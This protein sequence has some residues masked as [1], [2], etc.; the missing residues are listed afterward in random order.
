[1]KSVLI[2]V[3]G[4][5]PGFK[6]GGPVRTISNMIEALGDEISFSVICLDRD[7]GDKH[8]YPKISKKKWNPQGKANVFYIER[9]PIGVFNILHL[10]YQNKYNFI[11]LNSSLSFQFSILPL[12]LLKI[13][14]LK[15]PAI[16]GP[17]GEFS[18]G[19]LSIKPY[20]KKFFIKLAKLLHLYQ[21]VIWHASSA[22]EATD[23]RRVMGQAVDIRIATDI[24]VYTDDI[25][26]P[27]RDTS[28]PLKIAFIARIS[29]MKNLDYA[30]DI[31][32]GVSKSVVFDVYG[33]LEETSYWEKCLQQTNNLP[34]NIKFNYLGTLQPD[35]VVSTLTNYDLFFLP[36]KG[37]NFGHVIAEALFAGLPVLISDQTPWRQLNQKHLGWDLSLSNQDSFQTAIDQCITHSSDEYYVWRTHI[38]GWALKNIGN[39]EAI[40]AT[41]QIFS[42]K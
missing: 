24:S 17:R 1:M 38:R 15:T 6:S 3:P 4:Y 14:R 2:L 5:L 31:L 12:I 32:S 42:I 11:H 20:K 22:H 21:N 39:K 18:Q 30:I 25:V 34:K 13:L 33:P 23:I 19:A 35:A 29:P 8:P 26:I 28:Q 7:L 10:L 40:D 37:E 27:R 9:G 16:L 36:T 41:R